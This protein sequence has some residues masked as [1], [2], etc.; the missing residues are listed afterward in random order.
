MLVKKIKG[1][2]SSEEISQAEDNL[3]KQSNELLDQYSVGAALNPEGD[4]AKS[5]IEEA[6]VNTSVSKLD[7]DKGEIKD[8]NKKLKEVINIRSEQMKLPVKDRTQPSGEQ[9]FNKNY[10]SDNLDQT[11]I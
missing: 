2:A 11:E 4:L 8:Q 6:D 3:K 1:K 5:I 7:P 9:F 10:K